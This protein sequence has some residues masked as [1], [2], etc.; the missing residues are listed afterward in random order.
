MKNITNDRYNILFIVYVVLDVI[1]TGLLFKSPSMGVFIEETNLL[2]NCI[3]NTLGLGIGF[4]AFWV[5]KQIT[6]E[7]LI[8]LINWQNSKIPKVGYVTY[9]MVLSMSIYVVA[10]NIYLLFTY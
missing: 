1:T 10:Y 2:V 6:F 4:L 7:I 8:Y 3:F 5:I 9:I